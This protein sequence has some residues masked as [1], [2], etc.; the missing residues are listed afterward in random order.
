MTTEKKL[1][2]AI[3]GAGMVTCY[4]LKAWSRLTSA[5]VVAIYNRH[6]D[7]AMNRAKEFSIP[8][9]YSDV[10][11]MLVEERPDALDIA[12]STE[13][14]SE[15]ARMAAHHGVA[16]LCQKPMTPSLKESET[17]VAEIGEKV[18][19]MVHE[20]WRFRPQYRQ[21]AT[22]IKGGKTGP[23]REFRIS[24]RS[25]GLITKNEKGFP[26]AL[27]RQPFFAHMKR[28]IILELLI[29]HLD[30]ARFLVGEMDVVCTRILHVSPDIV[31][32]DV[33]Q[34]LLKAKNGAIGTVSGNLSAAGFPKL[35]QDRLELIGE[36]SSILFD[37]KVL[38]L[39]GESNEIVRFD[40]EEAY[41]RSYNNAIA[42]FV[43]ALRTGKPFETDRL[44]NLKTLRLVDEAYRLAGSR[45]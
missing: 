7:K 13:V 36:R 43:E 37:G 29:H 15:L 27:E 5:E 4:H 28:F 45:E 17:L 18:R 34:I 25:S 33:A 32:E 22:W 9:V 10:E 38:S 20:N 3:A 41:Q 30:T 26:F 42:H 11:K 6:L 14:H 24:I 19:F 35:P 2:V 31:G 44:D 21:A 39:I 40:F 8:K 16:I 1:R 12:A 23:I